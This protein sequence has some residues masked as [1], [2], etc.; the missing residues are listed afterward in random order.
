[1]ARFDSLIAPPR[2]RG[3]AHQV[4][5]APSRCLWLVLDGHPACSSPPAVRTAAP[6]PR[7][8]RHGLLPVVGS[9]GVAELHD[10]QVLA[11]LDEVA[12]QLETTSRSSRRA[13]RAAPRER[14]VGS[15]CGLRSDHAAST[16]AV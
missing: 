1:M 12:H 16:R 5:A 14:V 10:G 8:S 3:V 11:A 15:G 6:R 7:T 4:R 9:R 13:P 2:E